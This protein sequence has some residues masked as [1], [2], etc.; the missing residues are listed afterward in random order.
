MGIGSF[1]RALIRWSTTRPP[2]SASPWRWSATA[3]S[4]TDTYKKVEGNAYFSPDSIDRSVVL[5]SEKT[6]V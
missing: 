5:D 3:K 2:T 1:L 4:R 6:Y